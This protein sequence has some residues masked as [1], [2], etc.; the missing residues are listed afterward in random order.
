MNR[1]IKAASLLCM[2]AALLFVLSAC[3]PV[4]ASSLFKR[5]A[6][7]KEET[8]PTA[9]STAVK[10]I[11]IVQMDEQPSFNTAREAFVRQL[12]VKGFKD[13]GNISIDY[14]NARKDQIDLKTICQRFVDNKYDL[15]VAMGTQSAEAAEDVTRDIP[16]L[17]SACAGPVGSELTGSLGKPGK[18]MTGT[19]DAVSADKVME[20]ARKITPR[21]RIIGAMYDPGL[22]ESVSA[23]SSLR[24]YAGKNGLTVLECTVSGP[25][26]VQRAA[27]LLSG[28]VDAIFLP[29]DS[30]VV[31]EMPAVAQAAKD[32]KIPVYS[33]TDSIVKG[34]GLAAYAVNYT[35]LGQETA[36]MAVEILSG[37]NPGDMPV[38]IINDMDIYVNKTTSKEIG[39]T[40]PE[41]I[42]KGAKQ[43]SGS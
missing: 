31:Q 19:S 5:L 26:E 21:I 37:K 28:K 12:A 3:I 42:L 1:P 22:P 10:K 16:I 36:N 38:K 2:G 4:S 30:T 20:L 17:Y 15:I 24:E 43:V 6:A 9:V 7:A 27:R 25:S 14:Q 34:G 23:V 33:G 41:D 13:G 8:P 11:G 32:A 39:V 18:N 29:A 40:I 35:I